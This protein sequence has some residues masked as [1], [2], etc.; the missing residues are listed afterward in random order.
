MTRTL[1]LVLTIAGLIAGTSAV[2][3]AQEQAAQAPADVQRAGQ[4]PSPAQYEQLTVPADTV[5]GIKLDTEISTR[6]AKV[7]D[8]VSARVTREVVVGRRVA[9]PTETRLD[10]VVSFVQRGG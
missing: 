2:P 9:I 8:K 6:T 10:G 3:A 7:E 4:A 5:V 1:L